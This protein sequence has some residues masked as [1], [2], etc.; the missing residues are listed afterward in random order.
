ML[1]LLNLSVPFIPLTMRCK[2][3]LLP[4]PEFIC[5]RLKTIKNCDYARSVRPTFAISANKTVSFGWFLRTTDGVAAAGDG[6]VFLFSCELGQE[7]CVEE[8]T[9]ETS[10]DWLNLRPC[11][12]CSAGCLLHLGPKVQG[13]LRDAR[14]GQEGVGGLRRHH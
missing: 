1:R 3:L 13:C 9:D 5:S 7:I 4:T 14:G 11:F 6:V 10:I 12:R 2:T 8:N